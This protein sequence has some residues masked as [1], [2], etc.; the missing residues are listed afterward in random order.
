MA[1]QNHRPGQFKP[2]QQGQQ[3][4][5]QVRPVWSIFRAGGQGGVA[6]A[7]QV[8]GDDAKVRGERLKD[9][10]IGE[11]VKAVG[12]GKDDIG[13]PFRIS[14]IEQGHL[15]RLSAGGQIKGAA[16]EQSHGLRR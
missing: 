10:A 1:G 15:P 5:A 13:G 4:I 2:L 8:I 6:V 14:E 12:V 11:G 7:A 16:A 9:V 3:I